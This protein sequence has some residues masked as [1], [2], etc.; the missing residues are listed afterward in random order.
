MCP[1]PSL[2]T[3]ARTPSVPIFGDEVSKEV[4]SIKEIIRVEASSDTISVL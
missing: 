3:K 4:I 1:S 2:Y